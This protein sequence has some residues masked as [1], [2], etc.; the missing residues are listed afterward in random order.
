MDGKGALDRTLDSEPVSMYEV[1]TPS[2]CFTTS[3][4]KQNKNYTC[5]DIIS[6]HIVKLRLM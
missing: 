6:F 1:C 2:S 5:S 3:V 4:S